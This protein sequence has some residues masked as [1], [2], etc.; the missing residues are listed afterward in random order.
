MKLYQSKDI[1]RGFDWKEPFEG[2]VLT[3]IRLWS[4]KGA[5]MAP[6]VL[7]ICFYWTWNHKRWF[8]RSSEMIQL[9]IHAHSQHVSFAQCNYSISDE[10]MNFSGLNVFGLVVQL[11]NRES[12]FHFL[13]LILLNHAY[14]WKLNLWR[15]FLVLQLVVKPDFSQHIRNRPAV[16]SQRFISIKG[17]FSL[18]QILLFLP[19]AKWDK[20][21]DAFLVFT[22]FKVM[23]G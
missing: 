16:V 21:S 15:V 5:A 18:G 17:E 9:L 8:V 2:K 19:T 11:S 23:W 1:I 7:T 3:L 22:Q 4:V 20:L 6:L 12:S 13:V 10:W 14:Y